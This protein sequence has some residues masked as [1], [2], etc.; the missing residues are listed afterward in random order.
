MG[1]NP[2]IFLFSVDRKEGGGGWGGD[3]FSR[4]TCRTDPTLDSSSETGEP[5]PPTRGTTAAAVSFEQFRRVDDVEETEGGGGFLRLRIP[6]FTGNG[7]E[8]F[9]RRKETVGA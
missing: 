7:L 6:I 4:D 3:T 9:L 5:F 1:T 2:P 8:R